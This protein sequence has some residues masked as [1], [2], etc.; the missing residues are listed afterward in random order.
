MEKL[1]QTEFFDVYGISLLPKNIK[2]NRFL[3]R[4]LQLTAKK[5]L[6][7][8]KFA[9]LSELR[10]F[11]RGGYSQDA[12]GL[13]ENNVTLLK[14]L[15]ISNWKLERKKL[16]L[17]QAKNLLERGEWHDQYGGIAWVDITKTALRLE[18]ILPVTENN[19][20]EVLEIIDRLNDLEHNNNFYLA[21]YTTFDLSMA[22]EFKYDAKPADIINKCSSEIQ[23]FYKEAV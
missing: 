2:N 13:N 23:Y 9:V 10:Y 12:N 16:S 7:I 15:N 4:I 22:L 19:L 17:M 6:D 21:N 11:R 1:T 5:Y 8:T 20:I 18:Q 3:A 14:Q